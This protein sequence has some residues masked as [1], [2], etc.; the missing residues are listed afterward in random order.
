MFRDKESTSKQHTERAKL[1]EAVETVVPNSAKLLS[2]PHVDRLGVRHGD[3]AVVVAKFLH[4]LGFFGIAIFALSI[5]CED[6]E[7]FAW[8]GIV[9]DDILRHARITCAITEGEYGLASDFLGDDGNFI[10]VDILDD[11][12]MSAQKRVGGLIEITEVVKIERFGFGLP[13]SAWR[14]SR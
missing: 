10:H 5:V 3:P 12:L 1:G 14:T 8:V 11:H 4:F 9:R 7:G 6:D 2:S 13:G